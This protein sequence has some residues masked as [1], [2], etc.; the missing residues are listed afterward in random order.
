MSTWRERAVGMPLAH[1]I[2][3]IPTSK[4]AR[5]SVPIALWAMMGRLAKAQKQTRRDWMV[6]ALCKALAEQTEG[7]RRGYMAEFDLIRKST[8]TDSGPQQHS[9][10]P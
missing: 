3:N 2:G 5:F 1:A 10:Q 4:E 7:D 8:I 9:R 6:E